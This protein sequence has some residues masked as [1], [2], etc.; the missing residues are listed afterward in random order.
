MDLYRTA[1]SLVVIGFDGH[2]ANA[3]V[4]ELIARGIGGAILFKRNV[5]DAPQVA[6]L[7]A[8]LKCEAGRPFLVCLDQE[9][10]RVARL[11]GGPFT[12]I[13]PMRVVGEAA[14]E[15]LAFDVGRLL[16]REV[17]AVGF[18]VD[19]APVL[20]VD[21]NPKNPVIGDRSLSA[22][23]GEVARLGVALAR[24]IESAGVASC[25]KHFPG[26][27]DTS[28][29]SHLTL[30][31]LP[32]GMERLRKVELFPFR[33]FSR[34]GLASIMTAHVIFEALE[35]EAPAT[36]SRRV[37]TELLREELGFRGVIVSDDLEMRAIADRYSMAEAAVRSIEAGVDLLLVCHRADRQHAVID[38]LASEADRSQAFRRRLED[39]QARVA[40]LGKFVLGPADPRTALEKLHSPEHQALAGRVLALAHRAAVEYDPTAGASRAG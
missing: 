32:H 36:F 20:D 14:D 3:N 12:E 34:A 27:G 4:S 29:D 39:A 33:A 5:G 11:R 23:E 16:G 8:S 9:G 15:S 38:A 24:G 21:T 37:Q 7:C 31:R 18:D 25:G 26:H 1:A 30:P 10:G 17:R 28:Q 22:N 19:F 35:P 40:R 13:P 2:E 6:E